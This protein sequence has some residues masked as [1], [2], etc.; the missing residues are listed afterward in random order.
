LAIYNKLLF[1]PGNI[2]RKGIITMIG[3]D[4][5]IL[6][7]ALAGSITLVGFVAKA[8]DIVRKDWN[9]S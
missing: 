2:I 8:Y 1:F 4:L 6:A 7:V 3:F 5:L 9:Q